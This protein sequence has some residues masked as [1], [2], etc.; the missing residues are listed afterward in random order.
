MMSD[1]GGKIAIL[2]AYDKL[3]G[4]QAFKVDREARCS[5]FQVLC[6]DTKWVGPRR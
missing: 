2:Y 3:L 4:A 1:V 6:R 5:L